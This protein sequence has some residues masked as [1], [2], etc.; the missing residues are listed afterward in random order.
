MDQNVK[1]QLILLNL[2]FVPIL[3]KGP[4]AWD[5]GMPDTISKIVEINGKRLNLEEASELAVEAKRKGMYDVSL[6]TYDNIIIACKNNEMRIPTLYMKGLFK[7][8]I[9][10]NCFQFA[11]QLISPL[12]ADMQSSGLADSAEIN[13]FGSYW[14]SLLQLSIEVIDRSR[15][16]LIRTYAANFSGNPYYELTKTV[17][18]MLSEFEFIRNIVSLA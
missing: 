1:Q 12:F 4:S 9:A 18:E 14:S 2:A 8:L 5:F 7:T 16:D 3:S 17:N 15:Y 11:F 13:L 6:A 10:A